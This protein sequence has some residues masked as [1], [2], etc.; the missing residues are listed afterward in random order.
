M[1]RWEDCDTHTQADLLNYD[2][3]RDHDEWSEQETLSGVNL[4]SKSKG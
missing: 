2:E 3:V 1:Q 4:L